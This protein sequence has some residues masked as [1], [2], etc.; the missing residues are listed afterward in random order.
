MLSIQRYDLELMQLNSLVAYTRPKPAGA[1]EDQAMQTKERVPVSSRRG[2][3]PIGK[4]LLIRQSQSVISL[5]S[6]LFVA[7][8][9]SSSG[10]FTGNERNKWPTPDNC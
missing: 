7:R 5:S 9:R 4:E 2:K 8:Q 6:L 1:F 10:V 3:D